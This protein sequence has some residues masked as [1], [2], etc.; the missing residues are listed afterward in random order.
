MTQRHLHDWMIEN[1][2]VV[3]GED[4]FIHQLNGHLVP[5]KKNDYASQQRSLIDTV[6]Y[7][8]LEPGSIL[9]V[10]ISKGV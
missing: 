1:R 6:I 8:F 5:M 7:K 4:G 3:E 2:P 9:H 10:Y